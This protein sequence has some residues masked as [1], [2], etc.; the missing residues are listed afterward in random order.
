MRIL[1]LSKQICVLEKDNDGNTIESKN[2]WDEIS[3]TS[4]LQFINS[5]GG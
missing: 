2:N 4:L 3:H 5:S 1:L